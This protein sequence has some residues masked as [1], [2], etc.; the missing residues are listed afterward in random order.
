[1]YRYI[2]LDYTVNA[3]LP[4]NVNTLYQKEWKSFKYSSIAIVFMLKVIASQLKFIGNGL[5]ISPCTTRALEEE[6]QR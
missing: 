4:S 5:K 6:Q 3:T 1:M 2:L